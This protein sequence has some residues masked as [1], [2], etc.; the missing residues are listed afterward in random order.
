MFTFDYLGI[1]LWLWGERER[2]RFEAMA[3]RRVL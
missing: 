2:E 1:L 3:M